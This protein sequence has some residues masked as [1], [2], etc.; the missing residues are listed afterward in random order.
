MLQLRRVHHLAVIASDYE[1]SK[2]FYTHVLGFTV[3]SETFRAERNSHKCDLALNGTYLLELFTFPNSPARPSRPEALGLRHLCFEVA[4]IESAC[5]DLKQNKIAT[6][7]I[8]VDPLTKK[9][10]TFCADPDG[11]PIE[12]FEA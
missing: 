1:R 5:E 7:E 4:D 3:I 12:L 2:D 6:E 11:L 8:R 10:Y 9:K